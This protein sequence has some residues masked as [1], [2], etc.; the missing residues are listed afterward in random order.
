[1][2]TFCHEEAENF[3]HLFWFCSKIEPFWKHLIASIKDCNCLSD[4]YLVTN[5]VVLG[6][7]PDASKI[8][9]IINFVLL[10]ARFY[11]CLCRSK[12]NILAG[13][14]IRRQQ[15]IY[16]I[17][18][19]KQYLQ[20]Y[21]PNAMF[22][23]L[24]TQLQMTRLNYLVYPEGYILD[25]PFLLAFRTNRIIQSPLILQCNQWTLEV[26]LQCYVFLARYSPGKWTRSQRVTSTC[27][28]VISSWYVN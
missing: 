22:H 15:T 17:S 13:A 21:M 5:L 11:I 27:K 10:L 24:I 2:C 18:K 16:W 26:F 6:L 3:T 14:L 25:E 23:W 20:T 12:G 7:K 9:A 1:M 4:D 28:M 19:T 8:K